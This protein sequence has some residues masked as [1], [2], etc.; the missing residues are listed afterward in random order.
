MWFQR[1]PYHSCLPCLTAI[2]YHAAAE[3]RPTAELPVT[4]FNYHAIQFPHS[5]LWIALLGRHET[6]PPFC[7]LCNTNQVL[8]PGSEQ[9]I[10]MRNLWNTSNPFCSKYLLE[11]LTQAVSTGVL[12]AKPLG[13]G[14][15][16][17]LICRSPP[18]EESSTGPGLLVLLQA[19]LTCH[20]Q[21][22]SSRVQVMNLLEVHHLFRLLCKRSLLSNCL[23]SQAQKLML[24]CK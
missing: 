21:C 9:S 11:T 18:G 17:R 10:R 24:K 20:L 12:P 7:F 2:S 8:H 6:H 5:K 1:L 23:L 15:G 14:D 3:T 4:S 16:W 19:I 22:A 13:R